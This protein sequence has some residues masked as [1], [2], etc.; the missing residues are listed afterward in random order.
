MLLAFSRQNG[1][2]G[3][4]LTCDRQCV[5]LN[6]VNWEQNLCL[7]SQCIVF[8][9]EGNPFVASEDFASAVASSDN[10][11]VIITR[12]SLPNLPYS[13]EEIYGIRTSSR[14][15]GLKKTYNEL[16]HLYGNVSSSELSLAE[17]AILE[18]SNAGFEFYNAVLH[19][20]LFCISA[21]GK[22][23]IPGLLRRNTSDRLTLVIA[24]GAAFGPEMEHIERLL[25]AGKKIALYL[26]ESFEWNILCAGLIDDSEIA[27]ILAHP[28]DYIDSTR[29]TSWEQFFTALLVQ[30]TDGSYLKYSKSKLNQAYLQDKES[31][32]ILKTMPA[33]KTLFG[34]D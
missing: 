29:Y 21:G 11:F 15:A 24:D 34:S 19:E 32:A 22:S 23:A 9:D 27:K 3:V 14:Y 5:V 33:L 4:N 17:Q 13:V 12:D 28:E 16:Y 30:K 31:A 8:I 7:L 1:D 10:Y 18:D 25:D 6:P 20:R 2:S 26:P